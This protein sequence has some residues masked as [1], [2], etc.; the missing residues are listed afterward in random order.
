MDKF[1]IK[2]PAEIKIMAE[3]GKKLAKIKNELAKEVKEGVSAE[4]IELRANSLI[5]QSGGK[6]SFKMVPG[7]QWATCV[8]MNEGLVHGIPKKDV[9]FKKGDVVSVDVGLY[10]KGFHTD[11][12]L[13]VAIKPDARVKKFLEV[14]KSALKNAITK[15]KVGARIYDISRAIEDEVTKGGF[16]AIKVLVGHG[17]GK[18]LHE[19]PQI[20]CFTFGKYEESPKII[21]GMVLAVEVMYAAGSP[22]VVTDEDGWTISMRDGKI[23]GL[24]EE[25]VAVTDYGPLVLT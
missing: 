22:A 18:N 2:T 14:G 12:S 21:P 20:P 15:A 19:E 25:T 3:G 7:Y 16:S 8:N 4:Q 17:V 23:S 1:R 6:A 11:T 24:F 13:T 5:E 10:Y 9:V